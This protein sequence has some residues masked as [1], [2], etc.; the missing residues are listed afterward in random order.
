MCN[1]KST[2][3]HLVLEVNHEQ[4]TTLCHNVVHIPRI[5]EGVIKCGRC[6]AVYA[7]DSN[8]QSLSQVGSRCF[9]SQI[10]SKLAAEHSLG[11]IEVFMLD[12]NSGVKNIF[13]PLGVDWTKELLCDDAG[14][15]H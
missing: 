2:A 11:F 14:W 15:V 4:S 3:L 13:E 10:L 5:T 12:G 6:K 1:G 9:I 8:L 7:V